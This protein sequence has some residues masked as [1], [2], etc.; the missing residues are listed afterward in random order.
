MNVNKLKEMIDEVIR[1]EITPNPRYKDK[2]IVALT[3]AEKAFNEI[4]S[5]A[6]VFR[7]IC[8]PLFRTQENA[9][10]VG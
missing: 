5:V 7:S 4:T 8:V 1:L 3:P 2:Y 9:S 10:V 6:F